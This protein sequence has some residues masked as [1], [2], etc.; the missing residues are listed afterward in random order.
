MAVDSRQIENR[1]YGVIPLVGGADLQES[2]ALVLPGTLQDTLNYEVVSRG[3]TRG[4][5][6]L[7]YHGTYDAAIENFWYVGDTDANLVIGGVGGFT[8]GGGVSWEGG[9]GTCIYWEISGANSY[10]ALGIVDV[11]GEAPETAL[12]F[13]D[14]VTGT[15]LTTTRVP[16][17]LDTA[18]YPHDS[19]PIAGTITDYLA[20]INAANTAIAAQTSSAWP[21]Y[22]PIIPGTGAITGGFQFKDDVYAAR[23]YMGV[24]FTAGEVSPLIGDVLTVGTIPFAFTGKVAQVQLE[25][26]SWEASDAQGVIF[27][28]PHN[29][30]TNDKV[31]F[32]LLEDYAD[33]YN[34]TQAINVADVWTAR[35]KNKGQ[36]WKAGIAGWSWVD[37]GYGLRFKGGE[38]AP[39]AQVAPL[40]LPR[41]TEETAAVQDT[42]NVIVSTSEAVGDTGIYSA[43]TNIENIYIDDATT[44]DTLISAEG[45]SQLIECSPTDYVDASDAE[46]IGIE[47]SF[48]ASQDVGTDCYIKSLRLVNDATDA[49]QYQSDDVA[50]DGT[51]TTTPTLYTFGQQVDLW[52]MESISAADLNSG[53]LK[54]QL[55]FGNN[56][57]SSTRTVSVD[58]VQIKVHYISRGQ[59]LY[60]NDGTTDVATAQ[61]YSFELHDGDWVDN[62]AT[63]HMSF[64]N[65]SDPAAIVAGLTMYTSEG[66]SGGTG[67]VVAVTAGDISRNLLPSEAEL[68]AGKSKWR[69]IE[70]NFWQNDEGA[71]IYGTTGADSAFLFDLDDHFAYIRPPISRSKDKPRHVAFHANHLVLGLDSGHI[72]V[73][74][75]DVPNDFDTAGTATT[76]PFRDPVTGLNPLAGNALGVMCRESVHALVGTQAPVDGANDPFRTQNITPKSGAIEYTVADVMGPMY[77]DFNG[78][79]NVDTS[80]KF[81]DF[82]VGRLTVAIEDWTRDRFQNRPSSELSDKGAILAVP[83]RAKNQY[84]IYFEDGYILNL[85]LGVPGQP[86]QPMFSHLDPDNLTD[87]Y[88]PTWLDSTILST[89]RERIVMGDKNGNV[90]IVDGANGIQ[91]HSGLDP[92][93]CYITTNPVNTGYPQGAHKTLDFSLMGEFMGAEQ[94][95]YSI[96]YDYLDV[97]STPRT[98]VIGSYSAAPIFSVAPDLTNLYV[99]SFTDGTSLKIQ[100]TMDGSK[101]HTLHT[102]IHRFSRLGSGKNNT[103]VP[104]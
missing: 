32:N 40:F 104:R 61:V 83:V 38:N 88:V 97:T 56:N 57:V 92:V 45:L 90:W 65:V 16:E 48:E 23:D 91:T 26:G 85:Y 8:L 42:G 79:T 14:D 74:A 51:L 19:S 100:T 68:L 1:N 2:K 81:G 50:D 102:L 37:L 5:G 84:R 17:T 94:V 64:Q 43:I 77:A 53:D 70:A 11:D 20:F 75:V 96:G 71:A 58:Y 39:S 33:I 49:V 7:L 35:N 15:T 47:V 60:F 29:G 76:W 41:T 93:T 54:I 72:L 55:Q 89:G 24:G 27:F 78:V 80:D 44:A 66:G 73:S 6:L 82:D 46:I 22:K 28:E 101:P 31:I 87:K 52:G 9:T 34:D 21:Y 3:Y 12:T 69:V 86:A 98:K 59:T 95:T 18:T 4:Q 13:T 67:V 30:G 62:D 103:Q 25:A 63:G 36:L 10:K 99:D